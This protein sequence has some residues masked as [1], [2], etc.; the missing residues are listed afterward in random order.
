MIKWMPHYI[1][2]IRGLGDF[3]IRVDRR[4]VSDKDS[5]WYVLYLGR[6]K[7]LPWGNMVFLWGACPG[8]EA[9]SDVGEAK[10][11]AESIVREMFPLLALAM[12]DNDE[13]HTERSKQ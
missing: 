5:N 11:A 4:S 10:E 6:R 3:A 8:T 9:Y 1:G 13:P 12:A 2:L 7:R